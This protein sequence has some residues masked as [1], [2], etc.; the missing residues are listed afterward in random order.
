MNTAE[1]LFN[2]ARQAREH[3]YAPYSA[4]RVGAAMPIL[5]ASQ[6]LIPSAKCCPMPLMQR[7]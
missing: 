3:A 5:T 7:S 4:F 1:K 2:L 6:Q